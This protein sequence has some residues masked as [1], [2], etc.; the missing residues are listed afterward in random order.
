M[1]INV[2]VTVDLSETLKSFLLLL[3]PKGGVPAETTST[4]SVETK[5]NKATKDT[6]QEAKQD[7]AKEPEKTEDTT[8]QTNDK[9]DTQN[10]D[11]TTNTKA[12]TDAPVVEFTVLRSKFAEKLKAGK[13]AELQAILGKF[14]V[15]KLSEL[16]PSQHAEAY[17]LVLEV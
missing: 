12:T 15:A 4:K 1:D 9:T 6:K 14:N 11:A 16:D 13:S 2:T 8:A 7:T 5:G 17:A 3:L 10:H